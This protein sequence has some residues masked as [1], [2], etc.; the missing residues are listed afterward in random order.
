[1]KKLMI[2]A[3]VAGIASGAFAQNSCSPTPGVLVYDVS[4]TVE[5]T[6]GVV[7]KAGSGSIC[8][9]GGSSGG[10]GCTVLR[11][12]DKTKFAGWIYD[13]TDTCDLVAQGSVLMWDSK[14]KYAFTS[15]AFATDFINVM[16]TNK[17]DAE[18]SWEFTGTVDYSA[19]GFGTQD[20]TLR[21]SGYGK[22]N[23]KYYTS[24]SGKFGGY[25]TPSFDLSN[26]SCCD[27]SGI[28]LCSDL[29]T[30]DNSVNTVAFGTWSVKYNGSASKLYQKEGTLKT[31]NYL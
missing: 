27:P 7:A 14:R 31:P 20:Y 11:T 29:T 13:C 23:G 25:V 1:M 12:K 22:F 5:T 18:W 4:M 24:F 21:G 16:G 28:W 19:N 2:A 17:K 9:P 15:A 26:K 3:A 30:L 6:K 10:T 8:T